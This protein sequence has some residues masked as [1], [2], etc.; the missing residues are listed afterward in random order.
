MKVSLLLV[1]GLALTTLSN[2]P[3]NA[4]PRCWLSSNIPADTIPS[5]GGACP[6][7]AKSHAECIKLGTER[8]WDLAALFYA[9]NTQGYKN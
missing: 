3:A 9:C 2:T 6:K 4:E 1:A 7:I 8:G 5:A